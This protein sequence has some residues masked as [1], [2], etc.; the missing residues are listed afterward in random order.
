MAHLY[1]A[2][3]A[4]A[5]NPCTLITSFGWSQVQVLDPLVKGGK[6]RIYAGPLTTVA[7]ND[8]K[9]LAF[10][11]EVSGY[12]PVEGPTR[13]ANRDEPLRRAS[14]AREGPSTRPA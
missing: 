7:T 8:P 13:L 3:V 5:R 14:A 1:G 10:Y 11:Q 12:S 4:W 2:C 9:R 6:D